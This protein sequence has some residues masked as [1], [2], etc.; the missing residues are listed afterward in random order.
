MYDIPNVI[1]SKQLFVGPSGLVH[2]NP[3]GLVYIM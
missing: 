3:L 1:S 2:V